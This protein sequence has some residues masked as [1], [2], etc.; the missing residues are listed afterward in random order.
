MVNVLLTLFCIGVSIFFI[1]AIM[2][3]I[4]MFWRD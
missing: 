4:D 1:L 2:A 3:I